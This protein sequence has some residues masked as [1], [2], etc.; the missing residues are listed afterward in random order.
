[1]S[2]GC[3]G[4]PPKKGGEPAS[5]IRCSPVLSFMSRDRIE[6]RDDE[7]LALRERLNAAGDVEDRTTPG[8]WAGST[9]IAALAADVAAITGGTTGAGSGS[10]V[11]TGPGSTGAARESQPAGTGADPLAAASRLGAAR[12]RCGGSL[13][14]TL[15]DLVG[16]AAFLDDGPPAR[17]AVRALVEAWADARGRDPVAA[18]FGDLDPVT[19]LPAA[20][21]LA[22]RLAERMRPVSPE[23]RIALRGTTAP[24]CAVVVRS[25]L[26][27]LA[28]WHRDVRLAT[29]AEAVSGAFAAEALP[30]VLPKG[31]IIVVTD[32][33]RR[34]ALRLDAL[35]Q[36]LERGIDPAQGTTREALA[37]AWVESLPDSAEPAS[38]RLRG[39]DG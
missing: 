6:R 9:G 2:A 10:A 8:L 38:E 1:M 23:R 17:S 28:P 11:S 31:T 21:H 27:G 19:G 15:D 37:V 18:L 33:D 13:R 35:R 14:E 22:L 12:A 3:R 30:G 36:A 32:R 16:I 4:S 26:E 5:Y 20:E 29:V 34:L 39:L 7:G 25:R 24:L